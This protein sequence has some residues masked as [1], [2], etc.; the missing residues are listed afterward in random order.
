MG[1]GEVAIPGHDEH[2]DDGG[3]EEIDE[4]D[5]ELAE[6]D[7]EAGEVDFGD[8]VGVV[9]EAEADAAE[10]VAEELPGEDGGVEE[11]GVG[12]AGDA[13]D[14]EDGLE[15]E[16]AGDHGEEG[17]ENAPGE[18]DDGLLVADDDVAADH[19]AEE[20]AAAPEVAPVLGFFAAGFDDEGVGVVVGGGVIGERRSDWKG[21]GFGG[22]IGEACGHEILVGA[23]AKR[24]R[25]LLRGYV[26]SMVVDGCDNQSATLKRRRRTQ[27]AVRRSRLMRGYSRTER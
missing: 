6:G 27:P 3:E 13:R 21:Q 2:Q 7:H 23:G 17:T 9:E 4:G 26:Y 24:S 20:F 22:R 14:V 15:D 11:D 16:D 12:D 19:E 18:A 25:E 8:D 1:A 10:S 5:D